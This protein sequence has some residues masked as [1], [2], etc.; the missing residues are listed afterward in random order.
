MILSSKTG[1]VRALLVTAGVGVTL[2]AC[3][4]DQEKAAP[5]PAPGQPAVIT[6]AEAAAPMSYESKTPFANVSLTLPQAIKSQTDLHAALYAEEVRKLRQFVEG[7]QAAR[8]ED[9]G[10]GGMPLF[11]KTITLTSVAE[12]GKLLSLRR[13]DFDF[14]GQAHPNTLT[15]GILWD[16]ALK[17]RIG[18]TDLF[19]KGADLTVLD[20]A[21][22]SAINTAKRARVPDSATVTLGSAP[23]SCPRA[24][25][26]PFVL[27]AGSQQGKVAGLTFLIGPYQVGPYSEGGYEIVIPAT[28]F[29][30]LLAVGYADQFGGQVNKTGDVT[31][32]AGNR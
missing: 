12:T 31:P 24:S 21:L 30:S 27:T 2:S 26:T 11:E 14:S 1:L 16:K 3:N 9:G 5:A 23:G 10:D 15:S 19:R 20:Q 22:C 7:S 25:A 18:F 4:R 29:M 28:L 32:A 13:V 6:P 8:T 17:R